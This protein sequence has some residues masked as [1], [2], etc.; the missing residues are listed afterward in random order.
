MTKY[1]PYAYL[2]LTVTFFIFVSCY[3]SSGP[4]NEFISISKLD[5][6]THGHST[7]RQFQRKVIYYENHWFAFYSDGVNVDYVSSPDGKV[8]TEPSI[9]DSGTAGST[10]INVIYRD[11]VI[12]YFNTLPVNFD[13]KKHTNVFVRTGQAQ[14]GTIL[15]REKHRVYNDIGIDEFIY[16]SS[17]SMDNDG[18]F[19]IASRNSQPPDNSVNTAI[20]THSLHPFDII[21]WASR[22]SCLKIVDSKSVA[23]QIVALGNGK[24]YAIGKASDKKEFWGNFYNGSKWLEK[25][26]L[27][28]KSSEVW[29]DDRRMSMVFESGDSLRNDRIHVTYID[30]QYFV[31]YRVI[32]APYG[33]QN[34]NPSLDNIGEI[35]VKDLNGNPVKTFSCVLS[36]DRT[37]KPAWL[38]LLYGATIKQGKDPRHTFGDLRLIRY[39]DN[40]WSSR[41]LLISEKGY[42]YNWYPNM[43]ESVEQKIGILYTKNYKAPWDIMFSSINKTDVD[44]YFDEQQ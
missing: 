31:R 40:K 38:Y 15:W 14:N 22:E 36:I 30:D 23:T 29:G 3:Q 19:F 35:L 17:V 2:L 4:E 32:E 1:N 20:F 25:D 6:T 27:I 21:N 5:K 28:S 39:A 8:W 42:K 33:E 9:V 41:S 18:Y 44:K 26:L 24:A 11:S 37:K 7:T 16:Y 34:W 43:N 10:N 13:S 12:Y